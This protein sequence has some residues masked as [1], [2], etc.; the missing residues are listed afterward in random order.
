MIML[1]EKTLSKIQ[2]TLRERKRNIECELSTYNKRQ[3]NLLQIKY[4][5]DNTPQEPNIKKW[6]AHGHNLESGFK[7]WNITT[8]NAVEYFGE[9]SFEILVL[10]SDISVHSQKELVEEALDFL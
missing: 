8:G 1:P 5:Q 3:K 2:E 10:N 6:I 7:G 4:S 9:G